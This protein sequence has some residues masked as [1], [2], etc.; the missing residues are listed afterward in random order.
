[1]H[2]GSALAFLGAGGA[3][4]ARRMDADE[5]KPGVARL[6]GN[7]DSRSLDDVPGQNPRTNPGRANDV[8]AHRSTHLVVHSRDDTPPLFG[9]CGRHES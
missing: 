1:M 5:R 7:R 8:H 3:D 9:L 2:Q 4:L 6:H